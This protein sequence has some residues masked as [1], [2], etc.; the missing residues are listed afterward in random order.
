MIWLASDYIKTKRYKKH[1]HI[2]MSF[3]EVLELIGK[4]AYCLQLLPQWWIYIV[5]HMSLL[6]KDRTKKEKVS[7]NFTKRIE[8]EDNIKE[9]FQEI[10]SIWD[11]VIYARESEDRKPSE[12]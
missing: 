8:F 3:F 5:S 4:Q 2:F 9:E 1:E 6:E 11:S 7:K 10:E 12:L